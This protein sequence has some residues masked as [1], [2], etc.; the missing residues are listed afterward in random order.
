MHFSLGLIAPPAHA[1]FTPRAALLNGSG[2]APSIND[3]RG[4]LNDGTNGKHGTNGYPITASVATSD[5]LQCQTAA[6]YLTQS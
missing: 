4:L 3:K 5:N 6:S 2:Q 1:L